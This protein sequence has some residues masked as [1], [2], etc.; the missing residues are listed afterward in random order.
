MDIF[1]KMVFFSLKGSESLRDKIYYNY[2]S[3]RSHKRFDKQLQTESVQSLYQF[4]AKYFQCSVLLHNVRF[5]KDLFGNREFLVFKFGHGKH[6]HYN[7]N[8][9]KNSHKNKHLSRVPLYGVC[10][11]NNRFW[12]GAQ[13]WHCRWIMTLD[14][15]IRFFNIKND[16][17]V[18]NKNTGFNVKE[19]CPDFD[20]QHAR[21][22]FAKILS[23]NATPILHKA[24]LRSRD[25]RCISSTDSGCGNEQYNSKLG[26]R[27]N[28]KEIKIKLLH[29]FGE[30]DAYM[31]AGAR[32]KKRKSKQ[33]L[34][35][36]NQTETKYDYLDKLSKI[37][38]IGRNDLLNEILGNSIENAFKF[39][40][41]HP[42]TVLTQVYIC[43]AERKIE[44]EL[45]LLAE[46]QDEKNNKFY[47]FGVPIVKRIQSK[48]NVYYVAKTILTPFMT[49]QNVR[50]NSIRNEKLNDHNHKEQSWSNK[51]W[52]SNQK[53]NKARARRRCVSWIEII[54]D[55]NVSFYQQIDPSW[56]D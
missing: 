36:R 50:L 39:A 44:Y 27:A 19:N 28:L 16:N 7:R 6:L 10:E 34:T 8:Y 41:K 4:E 45:V 22:Q 29:G 35:R 23:M 43:E 49:K 21:K 46:I 2:H 25:A 54:D 17:V 47:K 26:Y 56:Y 12:D 40:Q 51:G 1:K 32:S 11:M 53:N 5:I 9:N 13:P 20:S 14:E 33:T 24:S 55:N 15:M 3:S 42:E 31:F 52:N 48:N 37:L 18:L 30:H 38:N